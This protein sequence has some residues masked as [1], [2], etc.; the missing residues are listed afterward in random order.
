MGGLG[1]H[2]VGLEVPWH[3]KKQPGDPKRALRS[4][5]DRFQEM[6]GAKKESILGVNSGIWSKCLV[7]VFE[8]DVLHKPE[9][10]K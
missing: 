2:F 4:E 6:T 8:V 5:K 7:Y 9:H 10:N 3:T 1:V